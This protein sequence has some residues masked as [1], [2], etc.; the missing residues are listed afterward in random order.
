MVPNETD[1]KEL[2]FRT[3]SQFAQDHDIEYFVPLMFTLFA[4][5]AIALGV[6]LLILALL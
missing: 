3:S 2:F 1:V 6:G 4:K 5:L